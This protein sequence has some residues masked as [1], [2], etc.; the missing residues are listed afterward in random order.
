MKSRQQDRTSLDDAVDK[1]LNDCL[2]MHEG[3]QVLVIADPH[4][5][6]RRI[7]EAL[8]TRARRLRAEVVVAEMTERG[9]D[10]EEPPAAVA[11]AML[12]CDVVIAPTTK[13][14]SHTE[15]RERATS[16]G[17]RIATMPMI[18]EATLVRAMRAD[19]T[20]IKRRSTA[21]ADLLTEGSLVHV[22]SNLGTDLTF[23]IRGREALPDDGDV[24]VPGSFANLPAGEAY[25]APVEGSAEGRIVFDGSVVPFEELLAEPIVVEVRNGLA[26]GFSGGRG[27]EWKAIMEVHGTDAF[28]LAELG[29]GTNENAT[30]CGCVLED[31]KIMGTIHLAFGDNHT[32]GGAVSVDS[33]LDGVLMSP[34]LDVDGQALL[35]NGRLVI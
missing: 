27:A 6:R 21:L 2:G 12:A 3:E 9:S 32:F 10:G 18:T 30:L 13:S 4:P 14:L 20:E 1:V 25:I 15:A 19:Y 29:I 11:A 7:T 34:T 17:A 28:N 5:D 24:T 26:A 16:E 23:S 31:E 22:T 8:V 33:H 35:V